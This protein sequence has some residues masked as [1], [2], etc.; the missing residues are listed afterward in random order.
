MP[1][2]HH[3]IR[4]IAEHH[5]LNAT[6]LLARHRW[7]QAEAGRRAAMSASG[8]DFFNRVRV[9]P[10]RFSSRA[11]PTAPFAADSLRFTCSV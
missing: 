9:Y 10:R 5:L 3:W 2:A 11:L 6:L 7:Y 4:S 1:E 8:A